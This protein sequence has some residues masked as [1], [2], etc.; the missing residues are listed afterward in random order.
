MLRMARVNTG[1][2]GGLPFEDKHMRLNTNE[3]GASPGYADAPYNALIIQNARTVLTDGSKSTCA[4]NRSNG[5]RSS[6]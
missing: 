3:E 1:K 6:V 4:Q 2:V 5:M